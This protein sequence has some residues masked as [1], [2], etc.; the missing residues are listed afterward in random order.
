MTG[1][2]AGTAPIE[3]LRSLADHLVRV[4]LEK[5]QRGDF[6]YAHL[7]PQAADALRELAAI[8]YE[9][10]RANNVEPARDLYPKRWRGD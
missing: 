8:K 3:R 4:E 9:A 7:I 6:D 2:N 10:W 5:R 1:V